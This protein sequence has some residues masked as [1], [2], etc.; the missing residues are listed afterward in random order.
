MNNNIHK[1]WKYIGFIALL[2]LIAL[3]IFSYLDGMSIKLWDESRLAENSLEMYQSHKWIV[4]TFEWVPDMWNTKPPLEIWLQVL[5]M[6]IVGVNELGVR[7]PSAI[8]GMLTCLALIW[9][10]N[11][12]GHFWLGIISC[13]ILVTTIYTSIFHGVRSGDYDGVLTL[14]TTLY[15]LLYFLYIETGERKYFNRAVVFIILATLTKGVAGLMLLPGLLVYTLY[16][17]KT[18]ATLKMPDFYVGTGAFVLLIG[19]Y[20]LLREHYNPGYIAAV[21]QNELGGRYNTTLE[22]HVGDFWYYYHTIRENFD[23]FYVCVLSGIAAGMFLKDKWLRRAILYITIVV[24]FHWLILSCGATK[25]E[26]YVMP[27]MPLVSVL[28]AMFIY[29]IFK[30]I[31]NVEALNTYFVQPVFAFAFLFLVFYQPY[32]AKMDKILLPNNGEYISEMA[33]FLQGALHG[34]RNLDGYNV[35]WFNYHPEQDWYINIFKMRK[36]PITKL[37]FISDDMN[38]KILA[39]YDDGL[40]TYVETHFIN[41]KLQDYGFISVYRM[42]SNKMDTALVRKAMMAKH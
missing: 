35:C 8:A 39:V 19:G 5:S 13:L 38:G 4:T 23:R 40:K 10:F 22:K 25:I 18:L 9:F 41:K 21:K 6:H 3:P 27:L 15:T 37:P 24:F 32:K 11:K 20:Y 7:M 16:A 12:K 1:I 26:W 42:E 31:A 28:A 34:K 33:T 29:S 30:I 14:F 2:V 36:Q 17:R